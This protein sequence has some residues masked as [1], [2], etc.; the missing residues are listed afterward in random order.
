ML[1]R[2]RGIRAGS[3]ATTDLLD[4]SESLFDVDS[5]VAA[6]S[7]CD[8]QV[9]K[10]VGTGNE[11]QFKFRGVLQEEKPFRDWLQEVLMN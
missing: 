2:A 9:A 3:A 11:T 7:I 4:Y 8:E 10:I 6:A 5:A 1:L